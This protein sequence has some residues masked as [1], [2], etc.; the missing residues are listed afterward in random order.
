MPL[1]HL[2]YIDGICL[3]SISTHGHLNVICRIKGIRLLRHEEHDFQTGER[4][5]LRPDSSPDRHHRPPQISVFDAGDVSRFHNVNVDQ[6]FVRWEHLL[7][8][9]LHTNANTPSAAE[10]ILD[11]V[12]LIDAIALAAGNRKILLRLPDVRSDDPIMGNIFH[13]ERESNPTLGTHGCRYLLKNTGILDLVGEVLR[14]ARSNVLAAIP[15]V[16]N[17]A[18]YVTVQQRLGLKQPTVPFV[19]SPQ[20][21]YECGKYAHLPQVSIGLKDLSYLLLALDREAPDHIDGSAIL[22]NALQ[23][24]ISAIRRLHTSGTKV[25]IYCPQ[26]HADLFRSIAPDTPWVPSVPANDALP[27]RN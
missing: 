3:P 15:F 9:I 27:R 21:I 20:F 22:G 2:E 11:T 6:F 19:E 12:P 18:E 25:T 1:D 14:T 17:Y 7:Y 13:R 5:H 23:Q 8:Q 4:I 26:G 24:T 16:T 10:A